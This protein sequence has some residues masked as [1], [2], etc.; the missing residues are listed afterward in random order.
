MRCA[1][2][3]ERR[4]L[5]GSTAGRFA[6]GL[7]QPL[8]QVR[9]QLCGVRAGMELEAW[10]KLPAAPALGVFALLLG[11][12][13]LLLASLAAVARRGG[14]RH[15]LSAAHQGR[16]VGARRGCLAGSVEGCAAALLGPQQRLDFARR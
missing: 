3:V 15:E 7:E 1:S 6:A 2:A 11:L 10:S 4:V 12:G 13:R 16:D 8:D 9:V 14:T 5:F